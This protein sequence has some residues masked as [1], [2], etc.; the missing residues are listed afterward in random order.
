MLVSA[1]LGTCHLGLCAWCLLIQVLTVLPHCVLPHELAG[2]HTSWLMNKKLINAIRLSSPYGRT[3]S[4]G[5]LCQLSQHSVYFSR[6][7]PY[8]HKL[9]LRC[10][11][12]RLSMAVPPV[13]GFRGTALES[14][15][16]PLL[17]ALPRHHSPSL[18][19]S[20]CMAPAVGF[21][22]QSLMLLDQIYW[23]L[24]VA[25]ERPAERPGRRRWEPFL[26][27]LWMDAPTSIASFL[28][29]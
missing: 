24:V 19:R 18:L 21:E 14:I 10:K 13:L 4:R 17:L 28:S 27:K 9:F 12:N 5:A 25:S 11:R 7:P 22:H 23:F 6:F 15:H 8:R 3:C 2:K 16:P 29:L 1:P 20:R 26:P